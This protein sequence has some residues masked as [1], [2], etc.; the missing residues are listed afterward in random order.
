MQRAWLLIILIMVVAGGHC[1]KKDSAPVSIAIMTKLE[2]GSIVGSSEINAARMLLEDKKIT[3]IEIIPIDDGWDPQ[4]VLPAYREVKQ[5]DIRFLIT[6]HVSTCAM[7]IRDSINHD[8]ILTFSSG[9]ATDAL[10][11]SD[12][13]IFRNMASI[14]IEQKSIAD[15][16]NALSQSRILIIRDLDN[17]RYSEPALHY[18]MAAIRK[19]VRLIEVSISDFEVSE[20]EKKMRQEDFGILY[21]LVGGYKTICGSIVQLSTLIN[22]DVVV[23]MTPWMKTP[24]FVESVGPAI[25]NVVMPSH[26]PPRK[27]NPAIDHYLQEYKRRYA[28]MPTFISLNV[29]TALQIMIEAIQHGHSTPET[30][31]QYILQ[32]KD[33]DTDFMRITIDQYGDCRQPLYFITDLEHEFE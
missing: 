8:R 25:H 30:M 13:Y 26:Y 29:Y 9:A 21:L 17:F 5:R 6:S 28:Y 14:E 31:K 32:K 16:L 19:P 10:S 1:G 22:P 18:F 15:Y 11:G 12:D 27:Q 23:M 3:N 4:K 33:F 2:A 24:T 7:L 20:L